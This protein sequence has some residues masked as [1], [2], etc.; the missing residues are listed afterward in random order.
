MPV[1]IPLKCR[2][3]QANSAN[4]KLREAEAICTQCC[5]NGL[6]PDLDADIEHPEVILV[7]DQEESFLKTLYGNWIKGR[8]LPTA[9][10]PKQIKG[11]EFG[12]AA[13]LCPMQAADLIAWTI[14]KHQRALPEGYPEVLG[15]II[16]IAHHTMTYDY[17]SLMMDFPKG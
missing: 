2:T 11:I 9:G 10:W 12:N 17:E 16:M 1:R 15:T 6:P 4:P 3:Y 13:K 5:F 7:F 14:S 8:N